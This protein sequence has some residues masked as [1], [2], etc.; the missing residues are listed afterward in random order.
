MKT[1]RFV[2]ACVGILASL[3]TSQADAATST[4]GAADQA[5]L[6]KEGAYLARLGDCVACHTAKG[7]KPFAGGL[8]IDSGLGTIYSTNITPDRAHGIGAYTEAQFGDALRHGKRADGSNLYPAMPYTSYSKV[9]DA[10][11]HALYAFFMQGVAPVATTPPQTDLSFPFNQRW[12][13]SLWNWAFADRTPF[14]APD[15]ASAQVAR[16]AYIV[17][18]LGHCSSCHTARGFAM[19]EKSRPGDNGFLSGAYLN[20]WLAPSLRAA[21]KPGD[22][23]V[24]GWTHAELVDYLGSGRNTHAAVTGEMKDVIAHSTSWFNDDDLSAVAAYLKTL[25]ASAQ[26]SVADASGA[27]QQTQAKLTAA[28]NLTLGER[29][30]LDN[31]AACHAVTGQGAARVFPSLA[32]NSTV[33]ASDPTGLLHVMLAGASM[34]STVRSPSALPMP[35][36]AVRLSDDEAA[37]LATFVRSGWGNRGAAVTASD[38]EKIRASLPKPGTLTAGDAHHPAGVQ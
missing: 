27:R 38:V 1:T 17:E 28:K 3:L 6:V 8:P 12:G 13:L 35:G 2:L 33:N 14:S 24:A 18:G 37:Q 19:Q 4:T 16:G 20:R 31:C 23:G 9:S 36:F 5:Q 25:P 26:A 34:P 21:G 29:L 15:G 32:G 22:R 11:V 30:F 10:D 7:G